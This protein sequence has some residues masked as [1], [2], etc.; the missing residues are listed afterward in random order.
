MQITKTPEL[1]MCKYS[2]H[3]D[4]KKPWCFHLA[5]IFRV[6]A[7]VSYRRGFSDC[8]KHDNQKIPVGKLTWHPIAVSG[9]QTDN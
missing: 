4:I 1:Y 5:P 7:R 9:Q 8:Q 6:N 3:P 2:E